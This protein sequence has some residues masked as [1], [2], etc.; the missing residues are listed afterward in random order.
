MTIAAKAVGEEPAQARTHASRRAGRGRLENRHASP[1]G[2]R[3]SRRDRQ[4]TD[5]LSAT[6]RW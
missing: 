1:T 3:P 2:C 6:G 4:R 5:Y